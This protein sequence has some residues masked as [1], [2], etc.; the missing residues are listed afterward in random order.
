MA[1][2]TTKKRATTK[3]AKKPPIS[4]QKVPNIRQLL[5]QTW[6]L[7]KA[8]P[9]LFIGLLVIYIAI[10]LLFVGSS[11]QG[12]YLTL[13]D[14]LGKVFSGNIGALSQV[15]PLFF[16]TISGAY[17]QSMTELQQ[18]TLNLITLLFWL[19]FIAAARHTV[20]EQKV[21]VR[22][23]LYTAPTPLIPS[24]LVLLFLCI[25]LI[26]GAVGAL[27]FTIASSGGYLT[28]WFEFAL[29]ALIA[30]ALVVGSLYWA[31]TSIIGLAI[32]ALP[33]MYPRKALQTAKQLVR[34]RRLSIL[35]RLLGL[36]GAVALLWVIVLLPF[37]ILDIWLPLASVITILIQLL[38]QISL[39]LVALY[40]Y[41]LYRSLL[42]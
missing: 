11:S 17:G 29:F 40:I 7:L 25:Q 41:H 36:V 4:T 10:V 14:N 32:V 6:L 35:L 38:T 19:V 34:G 27:I 39:L 16:A 28:N 31:V 37:I 5:W 21:R 2:K 24:L 23:V 30:F 15:G 42:K 12:D 1:V 3:R 9:K 22:D 33:N 26:P 18:F 13:K 20:A 8:R